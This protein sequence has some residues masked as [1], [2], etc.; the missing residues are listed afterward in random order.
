V[1]GGAAGLGVS[2]A[3]GNPREVMPPETLLSF[4]LRAPLTVN[5]VSYGE[6]QR[7]QAS[8]TP[9]RPQMVVRRPP[10]PPYP[11]GYYPPPPP[12]PYYYGAYYPYPYYHYRYWR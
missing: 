8:V 7:L 12:P 3:S 4:H 5:P 6:V 2:A 1:A 11:Y 10:P 9:P